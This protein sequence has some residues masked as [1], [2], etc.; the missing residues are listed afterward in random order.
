MSDMSLNGYSIVYDHPY[1]H[2]TTDTELNTIKLHCSN[3]TILCAGGA[4]KGSDT[5]LLLSC[6]NCRLILTPTETNKPVLNNGAYW[7]FSKYFSFGYAPTFN[8][9]Q[10]L[11]EDR[12]DCDRKHNCSDNKRL[13]WI[14]YDGKGGWRLGQLVNLNDDSYRKIIFLS[15]K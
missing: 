2:A 10:F 9:N 15:K 1:S 8:I 13:S 3:E 12:H 5:L 11:E 14:I 4:S 7:Y 6:G